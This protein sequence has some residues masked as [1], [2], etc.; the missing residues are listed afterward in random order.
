MKGGRDSEEERREPGWSCRR[1][2][3]RRR[4]SRSRPLA[5]YSSLSLPLPTSLFPSFSL[6]LSLPL[7][8][9]L[10]TPLSLLPPLSLS[11]AMSISLSLSL[12]FFLF[13]LGSLSLSLSLSLYIYISLCLSFSFSSTCGF[14]LKNQGGLADEHVHREHAFGARRPVLVW[15][16]VPVCKVD[17]RLPGK[18]DSNSHEAKPVR[19]IISMIEWIRT[20]R[21]SMKT[22]LCLHLGADRSSLFGS[23]YLL[24]GWGLGS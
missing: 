17:V 5:L 7:S 9:S 1:A 16:R 3:F 18:V 4:C 20:I 14:G 21:L 24:Q 22:S 19:L 2:R 12:C 13:G 10:S 15:E 23:A 8:T 6:L 11:L